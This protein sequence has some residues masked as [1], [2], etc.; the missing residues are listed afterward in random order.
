MM[1]AVDVAGLRIAYQREGSGPPIVFL[2]G[3]FGD[4]RVWRNQR[5]LADA[6]T[7]IA[8]DAPG[9]G[10]SSMPPD[11]FRM[12]DYAAAL[13][14]FVRELDL[15]SA[16]LVGNSFGGTLAL[17][18]ASEHPEMVRSVVGIGAYAGWS[19]SFT[20][21]VVAQ[22]L[23]AA[24]SSLELSRQEVADTWVAGFVTSRAPATMK[25]ELRGI[26]ADFSPVG[27]RTMIRALADA[28]LRDALTRI[29]V[30]ARLIWADQDVRSPITVGRD[31]Q[32]RL[33]GSSL[34]VVEGAGHLTQ[35]EGAD[36][37]NSDLRSFFRSVET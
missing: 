20:P 21:E 11:S 22:R 3:F 4:H 13:A 9:C 36:R 8:W 27:M 32:S 15:G 37:V 30:P 10:R 1:D 23:A 24:L 16:H 12:P 19:G 29:N 35:V 26:I 7:L 2:H 5:P 17:Q 14:M 31:L 18:V 28:D 33:E 6:Y 25:D 34:L